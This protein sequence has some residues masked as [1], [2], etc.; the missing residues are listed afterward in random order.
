MLFLALIV[1]I[2]SFFI[3]TDDNNLTTVTVAEVTHSLFYTPWYVAIE[4]GYFEEEGIEIDLVLTP[5][6]DKV[7]AALLSNDAQI[8]FAGPESSIYV[9][10]GGEEDHIISFAGLTKRDGQFI[11]SREDIEN[12]SLE[13]LYDKEILGGRVGGMPLLNFENAL[14]VNDIDSSRIDINTAIEFAAMTGSFTAG[15]G[16]FINVF[17]PSATLLEQEGIGYVVASVG[18]LS[19]EV[20]YTT[21][22]ARDSY[23]SDNEELIKGF[24]NALKKG[25]DFTFNN[26]SED[27]AYVILDQFRDNSINDIVTIIDRYKDADVWYD[28]TL[29]NENAFNNLQDIMINEDLIE[30]YVPFNDLVKNIYE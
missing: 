24:V 14:F 1:V 10:N 7:S 3:E 2:I 8:G 21:F 22:L 11:V 9:Y 28:T 4:N 20:P 17:E 13:D 27:V 12:F 5:G 23:L 30:E 25:I 19:S 26:S 16:D 29:I 18:E 15:I 6:A